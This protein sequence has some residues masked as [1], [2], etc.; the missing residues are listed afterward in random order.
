VRLL[1]GLDWRRRWDPWLAAGNRKE[2]LLKL[3]GVLR[4]KA[5]VRMGDEIGVTAV[6]KTKPRVA[7]KMKRAR[8]MRV[9]R[10]Y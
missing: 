8:L 7:T 9:A 4:R 3:L 6:G 5:V 2:E 1:E 10:G